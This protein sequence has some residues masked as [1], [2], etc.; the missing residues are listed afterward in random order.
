MFSCYEGKLT[1]GEGGELAIIRKKRATLYLF[2]FSSLSSQLYVLFHCVGLLAT[3][4]S[5]PNGNGNGGL[6]GYSPGESISG[7]SNAG[8][9]SNY[10]NT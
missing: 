5:N 6:M 1:Q 2:F 8:G 9:Q 3:V 7:C 10:F 4:P